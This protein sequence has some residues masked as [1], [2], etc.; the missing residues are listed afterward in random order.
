MKTY[1]LVGGETLSGRSIQQ[2]ILLPVV[3]VVAVALT[4]SAA[5]TAAWLHHTVQQRDQQRLA[6]VVAAL[7]APGFPL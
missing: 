1:P 7:T 4:V 5:I 6:R 3:G 2:R